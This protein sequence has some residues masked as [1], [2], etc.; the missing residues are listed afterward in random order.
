[1]N[2]LKKQDLE[3]MIEKLERIANTPSPTGFTAKVE[4]VLVEE[5]NKL[6][7]KVWQSVKGT[8]FCTLN[9]D[10]KGDGI[11]LSAHIDTLGLMVRSVKGNGRLRVTTLG[12]F[13][14]QYAEQEN[15]EVWTRDGKSYSGTFRMNEPAVHGRRDLDSADRKDD[16]M[17]VVL[18]QRVHSAEETRALGIQAGDPI[19][20]DP[21]FRRSGDGYIKSRHLDDKA[22]SAVLLTIAKAFAEKHLT[23]NRPVHLMFTKYEEVGHGASAAHPEGITDMI[24]VDMGVVADDL[25]TNEEKVSICAKD[26]SG[27]YNYELTSELIQL[28][29]ENT[30]SYAV[31]IYPFYGSDASAA[32]GA[33][34]DYRHAL[35]GP[36]VAASHGY[37]RIHE[38]GLINSFELLAA[39]LKNQ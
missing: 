27:P 16:T 7:V 10:A 13:P 19:S 11:L 25:L 18:D 22:S 20:L 21:R 1:M 23:C 6:H 32:M 35:I 5:L 38:E 28:A 24:A 12:G 33:G 31:D 39:Y 29:K 3:W 15:V 17:E 4:N 26:S 30:F 14:L 9:P 37:E 8:V 36:G 2:I 34:F